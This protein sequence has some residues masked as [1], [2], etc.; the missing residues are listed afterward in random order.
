M[1]VRPPNTRTEMYAGRF[2]C[3]PLVSHASR[4]VLTL[5]KRRDRQT[6]RQT[7]ALQTEALGLCFPLDAASVIKSDT[8][9]THTGCR[10][11]L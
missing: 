8:M 10:F 3:C 9:T 5:E 1:Y 2:A 7:D 6:D 4:A 11:S